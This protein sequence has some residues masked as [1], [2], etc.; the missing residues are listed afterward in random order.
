MTISN[1]TRVAVAQFSTG[2][3]VDESLATCLRMIDEAAK[4]LPD[5]LVLPEFCN[6]ASWYSDQEYCYDV[7]VA[8]DGEFLQAISAKAVQ[9][10]MYVALNCTV[11]RDHPHVT[12][13]NMIFAPDGSRVLT[14]DKQVLMGN[15]NNFLTKATENAPILNLPFGCVSMYSCMDGV[16]FETPRGLAIRGAQL[17]CNSLNSFAEDEASLHVPVRAAENKV[18]VAAANKVGWLVP[19]YLAVQVAERVKIAPE[20]LHGAG[21]SQIVAPD[22]TVLAKAP[23]RGE[24][25]VYADIDLSQ[26]NNNC[27][28]D[29]T[30]VFTSRR[31][32]L[33]APVAEAPRRREYKPGA[34]QVTVATFTP[35]ATGDEAVEEA[36][37]AIRDAAQAGASMLVLPELFHL[38]DSHIDDLRLAH[39]ASEFVINLLRTTLA[40]LNQP[41]YVASSIVKMI[42]GEL[43]HV[44]ILIGRDGI[45]LEQPQLH[46]SG[47]HTWAS[48]LGECL[49]T[50]D[51][52]FGRLAVIL[53]GDAIYPET[54]RL[55]ALKD[56]EIVAIPAHIQEAWEMQ[57]GFR[58]R[59]AENRMN[60]VVS[61]RATP[62]GS[63]G[64][65]AISPDF[66]LWTEWKNRPFDGSINDPIVTRSSGVGLTIG[67]IYPSAAG[68]RLVSQKTDVV[69]SRPWWLADAL[70]AGNEPS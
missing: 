41:F 25:V 36:A 10:D 5:I 45:V 60:V 59:A 15:E 61:S 46:R 22:G 9:H 62:H 57:T 38:P 29:G 20:F 3:D 7:A 26:A 44:A 54:F 67:E 2:T 58:E 19:E 50:I 43:A 16:I 32:A 6:H 68:N 13:T 48:A 70:V 66:T 47:S 12:G 35:L 51:L 63:G 18:F 34:E 69:D 31:P 53:G 4:V 33:Y 49:Y 65:F 11:R 40:N 28:P 42:D 55:A 8:L 17:L 1:L 27:R 52:P 14:A 64:I 24:A 37:D 39:E 30:N 56:V 23:K 21:E